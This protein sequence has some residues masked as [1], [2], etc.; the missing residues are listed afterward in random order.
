MSLTAREEASSLIVERRG[1]VAVVTLNR[2]HKRNA[3]DDRTIQELGSFFGTPPTWAKVAV[4]AAAG[5]H[6]SA[7]LDLNALT[8][9]DAVA[10]LHHSRMWH[11]AFR[12]IESGAIPVIAVLK[13]AVIGGGL[14]LAASAHLRVAEDTAFFALPEAQRGLF[15]GGGA[16]VRVPRLIGAHRVVDMMLTGRVLD[17][18]EGAQAGL[19]HY[20]VSEGAGLDKA[21]ELAE[22]IATNSPVSNFAVIHALPRIAEASPETGLLLES[23]MSAVAQSSQDAKDRMTAFLDGRAAKVVAGGDR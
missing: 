12:S 7:G 16:S 8:D 21:F 3:L 10:G 9:G 20:R 2:S 19:A 22:K 6:F 11:D 17:A 15:V 1:P 4:I 14:E 23:L 18:D 13:G 5:R